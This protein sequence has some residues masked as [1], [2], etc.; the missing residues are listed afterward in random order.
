MV[1]F[2]VQVI[3]IDLTTQFLPNGLQ[4]NLPHGVEDVVVSGLWNSETPGLVLQ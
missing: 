2:I 3:R 1:E 4:V